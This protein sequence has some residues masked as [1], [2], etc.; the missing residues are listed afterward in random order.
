LSSILSCGCFCG[1]GGG[2]YC[3]CLGCTTAALAAI[4]SA[5]SCMSAAL[6]DEVLP[7]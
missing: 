3:C 7:S 1:G 4:V 5:M 2:G 6:E